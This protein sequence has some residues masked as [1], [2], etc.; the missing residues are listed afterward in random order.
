MTRARKIRSLCCAIVVSIGI[1]ILVLIA[2]REKVLAE[3]SE[4]EQSQES[5]TVINTS[6]EKT[7]EINIDDL[8]KFENLALTK[9]NLQQVTKKLLGSSYLRGVTFYE[10]HTPCIVQLSYSAD[11]NDMSLSKTKKDQLSLVNA[12][13]L[14]SLFEEIDT[15]EIIAYR[16]DEVYEKLIYRPDIEHY[17]NIE[18]L[19]QSTLKS[20]ERIVSEFLIQ[21]NVQKYW[22]MSHPFDSKL[23][24]EAEKFFKCYFISDKEKICLP[25]GQ[26][27]L[28]AQ[29]RDELSYKLYIEGLNYDNASINYY[30]A[31]QLINYYGSDALEEILIELVAC[32]N[33][34]ELSEIRSACTKIKEVLTYKEETPLLFSPFEEIGGGDTLYKVA[35]QECEQIASWQGDEEGQIEVRDVSN[36]NSYAICEVN[37][38]ESFYLFALPLKEIDKTYKMSK[39]G[40]WDNE[41]LI[42]QEL[43]SLMEIE[44]RDKKR[45]ITKW[46]VG[47]FIQLS[48]KDEMQIYN[49]RSG[50]MI[51]ESVFLKNFDLENF[52]DCMSEH[53][54]LIS[55]SRGVYGKTGSWCTELTNDNGEIITCYEFGVALQ[56]EKAVADK[57]GNKIYGNYVW[58]KGKL[59]VVYNGQVSE[60]ISRISEIMK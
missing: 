29:L 25:S 54:E 8:Y 20:F 46:Q 13:V 19:K 30:C 55:T 44:E 33:R 16:A 24:K 7:V 27:V 17:F 21:D 6:E 10:D 9:E 5:D 12:V 14:M 42:S 45:V 39:D 36:D 60:V 47:P 56:A 49:C 58:Q 59:I 57:V 38:K 2:M 35:E 34:S 41:T 50:K 1:A 11:S 32:G 4:I 18:L 37:T 26:E 28:E 48:L 53:Y 31:N 40:I 52:I 22:N 23:G 3:V 43:F 15:V 51:D